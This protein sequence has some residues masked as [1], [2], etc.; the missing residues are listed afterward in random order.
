MIR[1]ICYVILSTHQESYTQTSEYEV[2]M[3]IRTTSVRI[4]RDSLFN[5]VIAAEGHPGFDFRCYVGT[6][7]VYIDKFA[8]ARP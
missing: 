8:A 7:E 5:R 1:K 6:F 4:L 2:Q 3:L